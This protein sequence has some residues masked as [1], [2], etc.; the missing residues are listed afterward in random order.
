MAL[1]NRES[2]SF[3]VI[4]MPIASH[5]KGIHLI[6][7]PTCLH[8]HTDMASPTLFTGNYNVDTQLHSSVA[9]HYTHHLSTGTHTL[10]FNCPSFK[11]FSTYF[12]THSP[13]CAFVHSDSPW[14]QSATLSPPPNNCGFYAKK[15]HIFTKILSHARSET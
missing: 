7:T 11:C 10:S 12:Q 4:R 9:S 6:H 5:P 13:A 3:S 14:S 15:N 8:A 2:I 1:L